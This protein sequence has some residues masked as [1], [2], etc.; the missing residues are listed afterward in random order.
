MAKR[1]EIL[2]KVRE[3]LGHTLK[4][5]PDAKPA[6][7]GLA[8][9]GALLPPIMPEDRVHAFQIE[10]QKLAGAAYRAS[11]IEE[12]DRILQDILAASGQGPVVLS[13]NPLL[14]RLRLAEKLETWGK[15]AEFWPQAA[16]KEALTRFREQCFSAQVGIT[17]VEFAL[18]ESGTL[19]L[20]SRSEG[21]QLVS[22][23]PP[24]HVALY[25]RP[26]VVESLE[27]VLD[28]LQVPRHP[29]QALPGRSVVFITGPSRTADIEQIS[30]RGVHGPIEVHAILVEESCLSTPSGG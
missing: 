27:E 5:A 7:P 12:L 14:T 24:V 16:T 13:R 26:Q 8:P 9:G 20:T 11:S 28:Q 17:G 2:T 10:L 1:D 3:A 6:S 15:R 22:L 18:A 23:A 30:I 4:P 25:R 21:S 29:E 19:I